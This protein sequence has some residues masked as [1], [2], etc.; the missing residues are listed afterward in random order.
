MDTK[1]AD[2]YYLGKEGRYQNR[3]TQRARRNSAKR[4]L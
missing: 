3:N 4:K 2:I 1:N